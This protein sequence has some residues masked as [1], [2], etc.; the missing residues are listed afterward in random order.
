MDKSISKPNRTQLGQ[1]QP[2]QGCN[3]DRMYPRQDESQTG[4][5]LDR[6]K[7]GQMQSR[8]ELYTDRHNLYTDTIWTWTN[9][10]L[11]PV[12]EKINQ[13]LALISYH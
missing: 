4:R 7:P 11:N 8:H 9:G 3:L 2:G 6:T 13:S 12:T 1:T 10:V 5:N